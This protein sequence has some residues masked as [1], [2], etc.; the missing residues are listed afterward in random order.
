MACKLQR[1]LRNVISLSRLPL[2]SRSL[3]DKSISGQL[4]A[5]LVR[6]LFFGGQVQRHREH[7]YQIRQMSTGWSINIAFGRS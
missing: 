2:V 6:L 7:H 1:V 5:S 4:V 3:L